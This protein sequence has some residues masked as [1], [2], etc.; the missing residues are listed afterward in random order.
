[1]VM[2]RSALKG[3]I[4]DLKGCGY[5]V[6]NKRAINRLNTGAII[7]GTR[8]DVNG[9]DHSLVKSLIASANG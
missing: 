9:V 5:R 4:N 7:N 3:I 1:M 8:F 6:H 2:S